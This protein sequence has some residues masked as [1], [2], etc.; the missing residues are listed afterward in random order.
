MWRPHLYRVVNLYLSFILWMLTAPF[1]V[2]VRL[3]HE[4]HWPDGN[5]KKVTL[6]LFL[7]E[8]IDNFNSTLSSNLLALIAEALKH[9][10]LENFFFLCFSGCHKEHKSV[11]VKIQMLCPNVQL[12]YRSAWYPGLQSKTKPRALVLPWRQ[13]ETFM[14]LSSGFAWKSLPK[15]NVGRRTNWR[16]MT[17]WCLP[18]A[19][20]VAKLL[21]LPNFILCKPSIGSCLR[22]GWC[23][24]CKLMFYSELNT[25]G[26]N[27]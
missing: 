18:Q 23:H 27:G 17:S 3:S 25:L 26:I 19:H 7:A 16:Q 14:D 15:Q 24:P 2:C 20:M 8:Y 6:W 9:Q 11:S 21:L 12:S 1:K 13:F 5:G 4:Q 10:L 22:L